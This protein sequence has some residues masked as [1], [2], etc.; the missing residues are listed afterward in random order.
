MMTAAWLADPA[1]LKSSLIVYPNGASVR[2]RNGET[3]LHRLLRSPWTN[4]GNVEECVEILVSEGAP[5]KARDFHGERPLDIAVKV[6][7]LEATRIL[8]HSGSEAE[9]HLLSNALARWNNFDPK[10]ELE[11][12]L[13]GAGIEPSERHFQDLICSVPRALEEVT[14]SGNLI[15]DIIRVYNNHIEVMDAK[16][17]FLFDY[18]VSPKRSNE[19]GSGLP[20]RFCFVQMDPG[21]SGRWI[22][23]AMRNIASVSLPLL[24]DLQQDAGEVRSVA[25]WCQLHE[26][27]GY[28]GKCSFDEALRRVEGGPYWLPIEVAGRTTTHSAYLTSLSFDP[29]DELRALYAPIGS[30]TPMAQAIRLGNLE[31]ALELIE[32]G[33]NVHIER[34]FLVNPNFNGRGDVTGFTQASNWMCS[35]ERLKD[36]S[37]E[38]LLA[39]HHAKR[40][41]VTL[42]SELNSSSYYFDDNKL[43][44]TSDLMITRLM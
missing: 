38:L 28:A 20:L 43:L 30:F 18:G 24:G 34:E 26:I 22:D 7:A 29:S 23:L 42:E 33:W 31:E 41:G 35:E 40:S 8:I 39:L 27:E 5:F 11:R 14:E 3:P 44:I 21:K 25:D 37:K 19:D 1:G 4:E 15:N 36:F 12:E 16:A 17:Q 2:G 10:F 9:P 13:V 6:G 32:K